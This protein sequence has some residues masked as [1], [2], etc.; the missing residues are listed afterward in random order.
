MG[1]E[2]SASKQKGVMQWTGIKLWTRDQRD[3]TIK[4]ISENLRKI[5]Y[6]FKGFR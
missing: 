4:G 1:D 3:G 2:T 6:E 5:S